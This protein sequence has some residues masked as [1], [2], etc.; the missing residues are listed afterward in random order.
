MF[1]NA[2]VKEDTLY[3]GVL[4]KY[5]IKDDRFIIFVEL[6]DE[7]EELYISSL[8]I[9]KSPYRPF[10][11]FCVGMDLL[12]EDGEPDFDRLIDVPVVVMFKPGWDGTMFISMLYRAEQDD[13]EQGEEY[14]DDEF[15]YEEEGEDYE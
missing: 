2:V 15:E 9:S 10:Y 3:E 7:P 12:D 11:K 14:Q 4:K 13:E 5:T 6:N 8:K 1:F